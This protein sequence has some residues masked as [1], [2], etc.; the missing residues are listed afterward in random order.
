MAMLAN[1][2]D[3]SITGSSENIMPYL[4]TGKLRRARRHDR[5]AFAAGA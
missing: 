4:P 3:T 1:Q 2:I 5:A